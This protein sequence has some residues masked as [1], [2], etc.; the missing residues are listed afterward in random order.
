MEKNYFIMGWETEKLVDG[1]PMVK[2]VCDIK[3]FPILFPSPEEAS[4]FIKNCMP[5]DWHY[6]I[7]NLESGIGV[8]PAEKQ[9]TIMDKINIY[10]MLLSFYRYSSEYD[11]FFGAV[12]GAF[13]EL[14]EGLK[15]M[16]FHDAN[17]AFEKEV[18]KQLEVYLNQEASCIR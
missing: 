18:S 14:C 4:G 1:L 8:N 16:K 11:R 12:E 9:K 6:R 15:K 2:P 7:C 5:H 3:G 13:P 10:T 17:I